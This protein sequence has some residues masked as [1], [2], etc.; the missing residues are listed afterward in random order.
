MKTRIPQTTVSDSPMGQRPDALGESEAF[1][2]FQQALSRAAKV[3]RPVLIIGE[4][5]TGPGSA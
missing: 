2:D 1:L 5:G 4:R 3:N